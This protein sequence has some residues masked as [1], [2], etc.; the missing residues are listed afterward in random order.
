MRHRIQYVSPEFFWGKAQQTPEMR[1][2]D[3]RTDDPIHTNCKGILPN[4]CMVIEPHMKLKHRLSNLMN[5][6]IS[7]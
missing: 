1:L 7:L 3:L 6:I 4:Y 2:A 5:R